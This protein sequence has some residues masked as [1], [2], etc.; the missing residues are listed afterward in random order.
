MRKI[1]LLVT[2]ILPIV[3]ACTQT[4]S[5]KLRPATDTHD[6]VIANINLGVEYMRQG[7]YEKALDKLER[8]RLIDPGYFG[9]YNYLGLLYQRLDQIEDAE[10]SFKK[11]ISLNDQDSGTLNSYGQFLCQNN[12]REKAEEMFLRAANNPLY[13]TPEI[14]ITNAGLCTLL[15]G[16]KESAEK[17]FRQSL[18]LNPKLPDALIRMSQLSYDKKK[19]L[20]ARGYF[21]RYLEMGKHTA[22]TLWLGIRIE[23][24]LGDKDTVSSYALLLRNNFPDSKEAEMLRN[25]GTR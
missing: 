12:R 18:E 11:A 15:A 23:E 10:K 3:W 2:L 25:T 14:P 19:Y 1:V 22:S 16:N 6:A 24:A 9:T 4:S 17:Y 7:N 20:S 21:Q 5:S 13:E 8:A